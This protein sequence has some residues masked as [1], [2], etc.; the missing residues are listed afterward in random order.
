MLDAVTSPPRPGT[1]AT[2]APA[3]DRD[4]AAGHGRSRAAALPPD[5]RRAA[6]VAA[7][8]PL[9]IE[10][11]A[12]LT[13]RQIAEAAGIAEGTIFRV[14]PNKEAL[15]E[16][17]IETAF[18]PKPVDAA[19]RAIDR[20]LPLDD[21]LREA[22]EILQ[23]RVA[24]IWQ[25]MTAVGMT[26]PP[27]GARPGTRDEPRDSAALAELFEP[28]RDRLRRDPVAAAQLFRGLIFATSHPAL[29]ELPLPPA[30][31]VSV[32]LD[33]IRPPAPTSASDCD[34]LDHR[35]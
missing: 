11:G 14:F 10:H 28:D 5:E 9:L 25:L 27:R 32:L 15:I 19:L 8:L 20:S 35:C 21:R 1:D 22:A 18:D 12:R 7:T 26:K 13:T 31:I 33:G 16:D 30:E 2:G 3:S 34:P 23:R 17:A 6:I 24:A 29:A 4:E